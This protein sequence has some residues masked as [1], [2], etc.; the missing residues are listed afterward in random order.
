MWEGLHG[1]NTQAV[2][3]TNTHTFSLTRKLSHTNTCT[4]NNKHAHA[5]THIHAH[6][7]I[8]L[9]L[10]PFYEA[11]VMIRP[12]SKRKHWAEKDVDG[13]GGREPRSC[14]HTPTSSLTTT[15][16]AQ[17]LMISPL[18]LGRMFTSRIIRP[19][20]ARSPIASNATC[21]G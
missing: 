13:K 10:R 14:S 19:S 5:R 1:Q 2:T 8:K 17:S 12:S 3:H 7:R 20:G 21:R 16:L 11:M 18:R 4:H 9:I 6:V 15:T